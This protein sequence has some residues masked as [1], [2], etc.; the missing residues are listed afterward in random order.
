[1]FLKTGRQILPYILILL[2]VGFGWAACGKKAPPRPPVREEAPAAVSRL[3]KTVS[4]DTLRL[5]WNLIAGK[6]QAAAGF[7]VYRSKMRLEDSNCPTCPILFERVAVIPNQGQGTGAA[8]LGLF[9]Y[10]ET[11]ESGYRY[12]YKVT[13][14]FQSGLTGKDSNMVEFER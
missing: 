8:A 1:M 12:I 4:G 7:Y 10:Q 3:S 13:A 14:Y 11:L 2:A 6:G 9:E 5:T